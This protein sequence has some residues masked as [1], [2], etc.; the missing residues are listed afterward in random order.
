[1]EFAE[2]LAT[3]ADHTLA[4]DFAEG[5]G[6]AVGP[7]VHEVA[8]VDAETSTQLGGDDDPAEAIDAAGCTDGRHDSPLCGGPAL[9]QHLDGRHDEVIHP[10]LRALTFCSP[11][12]V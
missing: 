5:D 3:S 1:V 2:L 6:A 12:H 4:L 8:I 10:A 11:H 9:L 7:D